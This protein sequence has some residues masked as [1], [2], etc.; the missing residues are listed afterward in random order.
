ML[1]LISKYLYIYTY[2]FISEVYNEK[3]TNLKYF[4]IFLNIFFF[5]VEKVS[6]LRFLIIF[7]VE[8]FKVLGAY[9]L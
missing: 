4:F 6:T 3:S 2:I 7:L 5:S 8:S 9:C 1:V